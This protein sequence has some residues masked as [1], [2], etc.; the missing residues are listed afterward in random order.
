MASPS[1]RING[2]D[3]SKVYPPAIQNVPTNALTSLGRPPGPITE[4][5]SALLLELYPITLCQLFFDG[6]LPQ[7][8]ATPVEVQIGRR[9]AARY[10]L[11]SLRCKE[12]RWG[13]MVMLLRLITASSESSK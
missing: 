4:E 3:L 5:G 1:I 12:N 6:D 8:R 7:D 11:E 2:R 9:K 13:E 10:L